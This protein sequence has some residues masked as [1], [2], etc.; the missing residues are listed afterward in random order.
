[1]TES[2][3]S[4]NG[5]ARSRVMMF[6]EQDTFF[7]ASD[8]DEFLKQR[9]QTMASKYGL[10]E[11]AF[12]HHDKDVPAEPHYHLTMYFKGRPMVSSIAE[13]LGTTP[14]QIEIMTKR[15]TKVETAR[16]NAFMYLIHATLNARREGKF[17]YPPEKVESNFDFVNFARNEILHVTPEGILEDL[18]VGKLTK[19]QAR[20][21]FMGLGATVLAKYNR[22]INDVAESS[23]AIQYTKWRKEREAKHFQ[24]MTFWF[25]GPTGTGKTRYAKYLAE[26]VFKMPYFVSGGRRDAMQDY[27]GQHLIVWDELRTDVYYSELLRLLDPYNHDKTLSSR[28]YN[29]NLM[30]E[31]M[32][33]TSPHR[34]DDLYKIMNISD[35]KQDKLNQLTRRVPLIYEFQK[36]HISILKWNDYNQTYWEYDE[37]PSVEKLIEADSEKDSSPA[38]P[39]YGIDD[40]LQ[41]NPDTYVPDQEK[42]PYDSAKSRKGTN[43]SN[44]LSGT[45]SHHKGGRDND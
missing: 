34:P 40:Y 3:N 43:D 25:C 18:G 4:S 13:S 39:F 26:N 42:P 33:I 11:W 38:E 28:Y 41:K 23:L 20:E 6:E 19:T 2:V 1:M 8:I 24:L 32:I 27:E 14:N 9:C 12:I 44:K 15:G 17:P 29:K 30:P 21:R 10:E 7:E 36:D 16:K 37:I 22:K 45:L 35:R 31:V 5:T